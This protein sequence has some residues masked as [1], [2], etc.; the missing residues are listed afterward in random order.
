MVAVSVDNRRRSPLPSGARCVSPPLLSVV[1]PACNEAKAIGAVVAVVAGNIGTVTTTGV[2]ASAVARVVL[3]AVA[4]QVLRSHYG[5]CADLV[6]LHCRRATGISASGRLVAGPRATTT[7][8]T[9]T[10]VRGLRKAAPD[11]AQ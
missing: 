2:V 4:A 6:A 11:Q 3:Q 9:I 5:G 8:R 10:I 1:V 7:G